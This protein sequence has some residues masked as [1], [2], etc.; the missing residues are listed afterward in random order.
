MN[1]QS[2]EEES[3][4]HF[5]NEEVSVGRRSKEEGEERGT[6]NGGAST[7]L[8]SLEF[9]CQGRT[10]SFSAA[11][12]PLLRTLAETLTSAA[13]FIPGTTPHSAKPV[14]QA[15]SAAGWRAE[16]ETSRLREAKTTDFPHRSLDTN[17][18]T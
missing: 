7:P 2:E 14:C 5:A 17:V 9:E 8:P 6:G 15:P 13:G 10:S 18:P 12:P 3:V 11:R 16:L 4:L 1:A